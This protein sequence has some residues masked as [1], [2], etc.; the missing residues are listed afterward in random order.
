M[1]FILGVQP[2]S[3]MDIFREAN[4]KKRLENLELQRNIAEAR[5]RERT[6]TTNDI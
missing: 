1:W 5:V 3:V 2:P 6:K 4:A